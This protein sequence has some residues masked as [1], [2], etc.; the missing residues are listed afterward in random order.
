MLKSKKI[1]TTLLAVGFV[2]GGMQTISAGTHVSNAGNLIAQVMLDKSDDS[3]IQQAYTEKLD[4]QNFDEV[5]AA[6]SIV[7][8]DFYADWCPPCRRFLPVFEEVAEEMF[9]SLTFGKLNVDHAPNT[10]QRFDVS[11]IPTVII[12]KD[13]KE[14]KRRQG[15]CNAQTLKTFINSVL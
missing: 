12:F 13:G 11:S 15:G 2:L 7:I 14:V 10:L 9:G 5:L 1:L 6:N 4:D 3:T 8:V